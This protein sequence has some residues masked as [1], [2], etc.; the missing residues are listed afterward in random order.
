MNHALIGKYCQMTDKAEELLEMVYKKKHL[1]AR[2]YDR[3]KKVGRTIADLEGSEVIDNV[4][5]GEA[6]KLRNDVDFD[7]YSY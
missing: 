3:I 6:I 1:S 7:S 5:I 2:S 4:H